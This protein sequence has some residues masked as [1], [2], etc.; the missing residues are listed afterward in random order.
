MQFLISCFTHLFQGSILGSWSS[1]SKNQKRFLLRTGWFTKTSFSFSKYVF[2]EKL[3][4]L[5]QELFFRHNNSFVA[6]MKGSK[7]FASQV[8]AVAEV[9]TWTVSAIKQAKHVRKMNMSLRSE[10]K[11]LKEEVSS[12]KGKLGKLAKWSKE[13]VLSKF[14]Y[15][16]TVI[17]LKLFEIFWCPYTCVEWLKKSQ[18]WV[19]VALRVMCLIW[20]TYSSFV[21]RYETAVDDCLCWK[22]EFECWG[23]QIFKGM[24]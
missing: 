21:A 10:N 8:D 6:V 24:T 9:Y 5:S 20:M 15:I 19:I 12:L 14:W 4:T 16:L 1:F 23:Q 3:W 13:N 17:I 22:L 7:S 2:C 11:M 18:T